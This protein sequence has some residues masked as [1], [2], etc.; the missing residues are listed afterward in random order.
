M[1][2]S[3]TIA[4]PRAFDGIRQLLAEADLPEPDP[5]L[6]RLSDFRE[7]TLDGRVVGCVG[8]EP[9]GDAGVLRSLA[10]AEEMRGRGL[11]GR[12]VD[13]A[14]ALARGNGHRAVYLLTTTAAPFFEQHGYLRMSRDAVPDAVRRSSLFAACC[15][16]S[17]VCLGKTLSL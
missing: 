2:E 9:Y 3:L 10:V 14:E 7:I 1:T 8:V 12:L 16:A 11:G 15:P 17:A 13:A 4:V 5:D 6:S